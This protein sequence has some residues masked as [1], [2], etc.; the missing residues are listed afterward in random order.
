MKCTQCKKELTDAKIRSGIYKYCSMVCARSHTISKRSLKYKNTKSGTYDSKLEELQGGTLEQLL[1][2]GKLKSIKRQVKYDV[3]A[4]NYLAKSWVNF[5][6][7]KF[8]YIIITN[9]GKKIIWETKGL[10]L[11]E[12]A[13]KYDLFKINMDFLYPDVYAFWIVYKKDQNEY[14]KKLLDICD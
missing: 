4:Y 1:R 7:C 5:G 6:Y 13:R 8:D 9:N 3:K 14:I 2:A 10:L 11:R 12:Q